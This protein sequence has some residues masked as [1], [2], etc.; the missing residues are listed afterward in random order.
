MLIDKN[1]QF[2]EIFL[3]H[4]PPPFS[5]SDRD[6]IM[7]LLEVNSIL[8]CA[9]DWQSCQSCFH[10]FSF[11]IDLGIPVEFHGIEIF[12]KI[13]TETKLKLILDV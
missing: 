13:K 6:R 11:E 12:T 5:I 10:Y 8:A 4:T 2:Y 3:T 9:R 7:F 1:C